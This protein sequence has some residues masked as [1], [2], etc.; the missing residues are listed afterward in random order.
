MV[1]FFFPSRRN[2]FPS[3]NSSSTRGVFAERTPEHSF[4]FLSHFFRFFFLQ[5][6]EE[7]AA[8]TPQ[9]L[10]IPPVTAASV[11]KTKIIRDLDKKPNADV[12]ER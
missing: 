12:S 2:L 7:F 10:K 3:L 1:F 11:V 5:Q 9:R 6:G 4:R 8:I